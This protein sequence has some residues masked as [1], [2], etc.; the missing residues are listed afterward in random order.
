MEELNG[1]P[2]IY[3]IILIDYQDI[4]NKTFKFFSVYASNLYI[5]GITYRILI[6]CLAQSLNKAFL[7]KERY[8]TALHSQLNK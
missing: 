2:S 1:L 5:F 3:P 6:V 4:E 7:C 8:V